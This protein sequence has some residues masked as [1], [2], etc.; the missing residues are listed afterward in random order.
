M[1]VKELIKNKGIGY[2]IC[3]GAGV[4]ALVMAIV[5]LATYSTAL[6]NQQSGVAV[7][8]MLIVGFVLQVALTFLPLRFGAIIPLIVYTIAFGMVL[9]LIAPAI[10]DQVNNVHYQGGSFGTCIFYA[11]ATLVIAVSTVV[12]CF[13]AQTK[14]G[15]TLI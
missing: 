12:A 2:W 1:N 4:L 13:F 8:V 6:P 11:V 15:K 3:A 14:D 10:A 7:G 5:V 9:N